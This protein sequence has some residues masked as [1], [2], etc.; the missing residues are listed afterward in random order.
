[1]KA[2]DTHSQPCIIRRDHVRNGVVVTIG[3][4]LPSF[5]S[6][7]ALYSKQSSQEEDIPGEK[8]FQISSID[9]RNDGSLIVEFSDGSIAIYTV[10]DLVKIRPDREIP[11][12][13]QFQ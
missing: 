6:A 9:R 3:D 5:Y 13:N 2:M 11:A 10:A 8:D 7:A 4:S 1:M 12:N